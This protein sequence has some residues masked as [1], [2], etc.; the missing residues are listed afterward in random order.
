MT[1]LSQQNPVIMERVLLQYTAKSQSEYCILRVI[2]ILSYMHLQH[3][4]VDLVTSLY[5]VLI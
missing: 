4:Y 3:P 2:Y 1:E 5:I